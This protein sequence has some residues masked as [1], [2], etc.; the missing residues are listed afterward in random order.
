MD[1]CFQFLGGIAESICKEAYFKQNYAHSLVPGISLSVR[2]NGLW[3]NR[4]FINTSLAYIVS[5]FMFKEH[6]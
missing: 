3:K 4:Y 2:S 6:L 1:A 5:F